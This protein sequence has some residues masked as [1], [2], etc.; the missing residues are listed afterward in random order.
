MSH[1]IN[2][3]FVVFFRY[4]KKRV[5][6]TCCLGIDAEPWGTVPSLLLDREAINQQYKAI[7]LLAVLFQ[8]KH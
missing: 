3:F 5:S 1:D 8:T 7:A 2:V 4:I 6:Q